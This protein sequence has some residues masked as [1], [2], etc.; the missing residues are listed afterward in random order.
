MP[1]R[2]VRSRASRFRGLNNVGDPHRLG[3]EWLTTAKNVDVDREGHIARRPGYSRVAT[4]A[5]R[6][7]YAPDGA[8]FLYV[9]SQ[10]RVFRMGGDHELV[11]LISDLDPN[12]PVRFTEINREVYVLNGAR[13]WIV[14][15]DEVRE[16]GLPVPP[17]PAVTALD[18]QAPAGTYAF[19]VSYLARD[20][21][22]SGLSPRVE[23]T[24]ETDVAWRVD[25]P[26]HADYATV[27]YMTPVGDNTLYR[28]G[29]YRQARIET[30]AWGLDIGTPARTEF[31]SPPPPGSVLGFHLGRVL[32]GDYFP[33]YG[34][35]VVWQSD[36]LGY[37]HFQPDH[38][39]IP[40]QGEVRMLESGRTGLYIGTDRQVM[41]LTPD[42][43]LAEVLSY[44]VPPGTPSG[45]DDSGAVFF[46]TR[47][48]LVVETGE[49][50]ENVMEESYSP[51]VA[52][53]ASAA[54][55]HQ[56]GYRKVVTLARTTG[57]PYNQ[58]RKDQ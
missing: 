56:D 46:W 31:L 45:T 25:L 16:W 1:N 27:L 55:I 19:A 17:Q 42:G 49:G 47:R 26:Q 41:Q 30:E 50:P 6:N 33:E 40:V 5:Y 12:A 39:Y 51:P 20:G 3:I 21:R 28:L 29:A 58:W 48:G 34:M 57:Q 37:E 2:E 15:G 9:A 23:A 11:E 18:G 35:S 13:H 53:E 36:P 14:R 22:E 32:I 10:T 43:A 52:E 24:A 8:P 44:G 38:S 54:L 4:G 7:C